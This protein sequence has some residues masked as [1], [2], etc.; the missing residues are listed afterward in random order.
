MQK[1]HV[2]SQLG[3]QSRPIQMRARVLYL[4]NLYLT[5]YTPSPSLFT[6]KQPPNQG[7]IL[8][9][10]IDHSLIWSCAPLQFLTVNFQSIFSRAEWSKDQLIDFKSFITALKFTLLKRLIL[11]FLIL[12]YSLTFQVSWLNVTLS[13][14][15]SYFTFTKMLWTTEKG[16]LYKI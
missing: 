9:Y 11:H 6:F 10:D 16:F 8:F 2:N 13:T 4:A 3:T 7:S 15:T 1:W 5:L 12:L 14:Y